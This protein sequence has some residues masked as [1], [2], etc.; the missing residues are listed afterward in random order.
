[1]YRICFDFSFCSL[2]TSTTTNCTSVHRYRLY[3]L[4]LAYAF[5][6]P[7]SINRYWL[8]FTA[9]RFWKGSRL[10]ANT[11]SFVSRVEADLLNKIN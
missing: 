9:L 8:V 7:T 10:A 1:M 3:V 11:I 5:T 4:Q 2:P 6:S